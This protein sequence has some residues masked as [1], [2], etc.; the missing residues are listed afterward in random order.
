MKKSKGTLH[1]I[2]PFII[3]VSKS[4]EQNPVNEKVGIGEIYQ[5]WTTYSLH[6]TQF[7]SL[8]LSIPGEK[9]MEIDEEIDEKPC[10]ETKKSLFTE[11]QIKMGWKIK[12]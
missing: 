11:E 12:K 7:F 4:I 8:G 3:F 2:I 10:C 9:L 5:V 6:I 1:Q